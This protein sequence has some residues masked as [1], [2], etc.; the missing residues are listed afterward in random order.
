MSTVKIWPFKSFHRNQRYDNERIWGQQVQC[1]CSSG[2]VKKVQSSKIT[3]SGPG[4]GSPLNVGSSTHIN[5]YLCEILVLKWAHCALSKP[6]VASLGSNNLSFVKG[7]PAPFS[8]PYTQ[9]ST[10]CSFLI[11]TASVVTVSLQ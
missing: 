10:H 11:Y 2:P 4:L 1:R 3:L 5:K 6:S 7:I 8:T 9:F